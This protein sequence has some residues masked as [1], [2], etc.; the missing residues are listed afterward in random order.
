MKSMISSNVNVRGPKE[1]WGHLLCY[2]LCIKYTENDGHSG[3]N[4]QR[5]L[6]KKFGPSDS[7]F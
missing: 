2:L 3:G 4:S 5:L 7:I 6:H 1:L